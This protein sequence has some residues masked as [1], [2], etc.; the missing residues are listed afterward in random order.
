[1]A[2]VKPG[3]LQFGHVSETPHDWEQRFEKIDLEN[4]KRQG[5]V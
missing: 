2:M 3:E 5:K 4:L 1:M